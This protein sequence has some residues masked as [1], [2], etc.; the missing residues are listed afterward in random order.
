MHVFWTEQVLLPR[1]PLGA[2]YLPLL[3]F[4]H[5]HPTHHQRVWP[6]LWENRLCIGSYTAFPLWAACTWVW[7]THLESKHLEAELHK[8]SF[9]AGWLRY[10]GCGRGP[11]W[12]RLEGKAAVIFRVRQNSVQLSPG[13]LA[14]PP[15]SSSPAVLSTSKRR[16]SSHVSWRQGTAVS[17]TSVPIDT[18]W[19]IDKHLPGT[20]HQLSSQCSVS[21]ASGHCL[22]LVNNHIR[23]AR[24]FWY[25]ANQSPFRI[26]N[27]IIR[28][29]SELRSVSRGKA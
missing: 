20:L 11:S 12:P 14:A 16:L 7:C 9:Q 5:C 26:P 13:R 21:E 4:T 6:S 2:D 17:R 23:G 19:A 15:H 28:N 24:V 3:V 27:D 25:L 8:E 29:Q 10:R 22:G 18:A 1:A